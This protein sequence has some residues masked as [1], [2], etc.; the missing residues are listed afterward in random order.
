MSSGH[1][2]DSRQPLLLALLLTLLFAAL[3]ALGGWWS[4]SL[5][6]TAD[7][8]H[9]LSDALGLGLAWAAQ[10]VARRPVSARYSYGLGRIEPLVAF[11]NAVMMLAVIF[12]IAHE[13]VH[14]FAQPQAIRSG[15]MLLIAGAGF[16]C[17][18][19]IARLLW[20]DHGNLNMRAALVHVLGDLLG[21]VAAMVAALVILYSGWQMIDPLLSL[22]VAGLILFS[23]VR[24]LLDSSHMLLEGTPRHLDHQAIGGELAAVPGIVGV[25]DLHVWQ[26]DSH[27]ISLS[28]HI[29]LQTLAQWPRVLADCRQLLSAHFGIAHVTLQPELPLASHAYGRVIPLVPVS[30]RPEAKAKSGHHH[31]GHDHDHDHH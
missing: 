19:L 10:L 14:R 12:G 29:N 18:L 30:A 8:G 17:N 4:G 15:W 5:A 21:S 6:L 28:A 23:T 22:L 2:H 11:I 1:T 3:E 27:T 9:M 16:C 31:H 26:L 24:L 7:A 25:H 13:A 20:H